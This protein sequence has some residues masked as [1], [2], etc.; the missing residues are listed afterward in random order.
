MEKIVTQ[1]TAELEEKVEKLDKSKQAMLFMVED[2]NQMTAELK[3]KTRHLEQSNQELEA[4]SYSVSHDLKAPLRAIDGFSRF[5]KEDYQGQLDQEGQRLISVIRKNV[6]KMDQLI[7]DLLSLSRV[8]RTEITPYQVD[9]TA[10]AKSMYH[11]VATDDQRNAFQ[12]SLDPIPEAT[13]DPTLIKQVWL[14]LIHNALKYSSGAPEKKIEIGAEENEQEVIYHV[15]DHGAGFNPEYQ[16]KL[17]ALFQRLHR[18]DEFEGS[19]VGLA[20]V[21]RI[22]QRHGGRVWSEG[23]LNQG[24]VFYFSLPKKFREENSAYHQVEEQKNG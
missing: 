24:A 20:I 3:E 19:G 16:E 14:N 18:E 13:C 8:S 21:K 23:N 4:F 7:L 10:V 15:R 9:M 17:F 22:I 6:A 5:L 11:E 12:F 2:L 1:R